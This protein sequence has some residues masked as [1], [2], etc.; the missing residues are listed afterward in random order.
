MQTGSPKAR[1]GKQRER[2]RKRRQCGVGKRSR[3]RGEEQNCELICIKK[4]ADGKGK[5]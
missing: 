5:C 1:R 2:E 4:S 3:K